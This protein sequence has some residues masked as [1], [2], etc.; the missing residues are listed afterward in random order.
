MLQLL[1]NLIADPRFEEPTP[2]S[3]I[4]PEESPLATYGLTLRVTYHPAEDD[5]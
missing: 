3:E 5:E 2:S 1:D 4:S